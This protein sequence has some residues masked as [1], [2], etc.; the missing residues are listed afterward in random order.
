VHPNPASKDVEKKEKRLNTKVT[1]VT[2]EK[3]RRKMGSG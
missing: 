1:K 2:K 3:R